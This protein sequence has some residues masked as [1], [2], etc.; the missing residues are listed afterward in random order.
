MRSANAQEDIMATRHSHESADTQALHRAQ[1]RVAARPAHEA[2]SPSH[3]GV[4]SPVL[5]L[6]QTHGNRAV[7]RMIRG[8]AIGTARSGQAVPRAPD[9]LLPEWRIG[10]WRILPPK[11]T[12]ETDERLDT[13][14]NRRRAEQ[15]EAD[16]RGYSPNPYEWW[17]P[18]PPK[19]PGPPWPAPRQ[20]GSLE[21]VL[22]PPEPQQPG[23]YPS[24]LPSEEERYV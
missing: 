2:E 10:D 18:K 17:K 11:P 8:G 4:F 1:R 14:Q 19:Q 5:R 20:P 24:P 16:E 3:A 23:D 21:D 6:Q 12:M 15:Q 22:P 13:E 9:D 7:Q